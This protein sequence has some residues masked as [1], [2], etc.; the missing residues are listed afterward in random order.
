[1]GYSQF[2]SREALH[3]I[4]NFIDHVQRPLVLG[5]WALLQVLVDAPDLAEGQVP[6]HESKLLHLPVKLLQLRVLVLFVEF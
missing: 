4:V 3:F 1:M 5:D 2:D 6:L